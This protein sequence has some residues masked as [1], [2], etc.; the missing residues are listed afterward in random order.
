M[1]WPNYT[2]TFLFK[3]TCEHN[4]NFSKK[5]KTFKR[6]LCMIATM[7]SSLRRFRHPSPSLAFVSGQARRELQ[8]S[9]EKYSRGASTGENF[10]F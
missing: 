6:K 7:L 3:A 8:R 4:K 10:S 2:A 9:P 5:H 1:Q